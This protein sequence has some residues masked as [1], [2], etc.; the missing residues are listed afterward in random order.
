[1]RF[2][3]ASALFWVALAA[4]NTWQNKPIADWTTE[5]AQ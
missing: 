5:D 3:V 2:I 1:L 4:D